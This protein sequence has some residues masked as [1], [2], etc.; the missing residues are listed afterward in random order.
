M[1]VIQHGNIGRLSYSG[2][3]ARC[4]LARKVP[5]I[6]TQS[7]LPASCGTSHNG[8]KS[9]SNLTDGHARSLE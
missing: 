8:G 9:Q 3:A 4:D 2:A 6:R 7:T 1:Q 5:G